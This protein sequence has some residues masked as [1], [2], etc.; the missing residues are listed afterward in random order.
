MDTFLSK[1]FVDQ[2]SEAMIVLAFVL[3]AVDG[4]KCQYQT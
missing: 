2:R 3:I 4:P 1:I